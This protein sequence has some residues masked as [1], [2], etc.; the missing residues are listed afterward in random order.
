MERGAVTYAGR[1][2]PFQEGNWLCSSTGASGIGV[3]DVILVFQS[4][5]SNT[6]VRSSTRTSGETRGRRI[7]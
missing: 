1:T 6:G 4:Q 5:M 7:L 2:L 3:L